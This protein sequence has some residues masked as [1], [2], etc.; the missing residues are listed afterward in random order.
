MPPPARLQAVKARGNYNPPA[1]LNI[2]VIG[3]VLAFA[4]LLLVCIGICCCSYRKTAKRN[5]RYQ[6]RRGRADR[7]WVGFTQLNSPVMIDRS[8]DRHDAAE[9][10]AAKWS[11]ASEPPAYSALDHLMLASPQISHLE[12]DRLLPPT[13]ITSRA[14]SPPPPTYNAA[15]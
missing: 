8:S 12:S 15:R 10:K 14:P 1:S 7:D 9:A 5:E 2:P 3:L 6:Q 13:P 11:G 4:M